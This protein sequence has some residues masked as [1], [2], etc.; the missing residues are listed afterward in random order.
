MSDTSSTSNSPINP[1]NKES[2]RDASK[3]LFEQ[4]DAAV[5]DTLLTPI[6]TSIPPT[7]PNMSELSDTPSKSKVPPPPSTNPPKGP[8]GSLED[9]Q[10]PPTKTHNVC[11]FQFII[12]PSKP[13]VNKP[14]QIGIL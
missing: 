14:T 3:R 12:T 7:D 4:L 11:G 9:L 5:I 10:L 13:V 2:L 1:D 6:K 8:K